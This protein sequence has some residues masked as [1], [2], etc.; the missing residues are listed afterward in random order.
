MAAIN[1]KK[2]ILMSGGF[3][4]I[5]LILGFCFS[6]V[7]ARY[8]GVE[9]K[10]K[11]SYLI[12]I[13]GF[14]WVILDFGLYR[15]YPY[16]IRKHPDKIPSLF[17]WAILCFLVETLLLVLLCVGFTDFWNSLLGSSFSMASLLLLVCFITMTKA[18]MQLQGLYLGMDKVFDSS[19]AYMLNSMICLAIVL[20]GYLLISGAEKLELA[21]LAMVIGLSISIL[22]LIVKNKW[23][24]PLKVFDWKFIYHSYGFG[25]RVF[26][27]SMFILLLLKVDIVIVKK[28]LGFS[29]VGIYS[30]ASHIV[31]L[32]QMASNLVGSLLLVRLSDTDNEVEKWQVMKKMLMVFFV[33]L[34]L[35]NIGF[36]V[37][38]KF[39]L[40]TM[41]G[42]QFVPVYYVYFWLMP[43]TYGLSFGSLFN[44]YLNSKGFPIISIILPAIALLLNLA[45]NY[46]LIP[47]MGIYGAALSTSIAYFMW[48]ILIIAYEE[49]ITKGRMLAYL[50]PKSQDWR[51][52]W[53]LSLETLRIRK[54]AE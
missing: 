5:I 1:L 3:R 29:E 30:I 49:K 10:G 34:S 33:L 32:L 24:N 18:L 15:S 11:L 39:I 12:T 51:Q 50:I 36:V 35:A 28:M 13:G 37:A 54:N 27:S 21:M 9:L 6:L 41:F 16:L 31:D 19:L 14:A 7:T 48:F 17:A 2:N 4:I 8:L 45:L 23:G 25:F 44:N 42:K 46:A 43:A 40:S 20:S 53:K 47:L 52:L 22:Y 26:L 38:G